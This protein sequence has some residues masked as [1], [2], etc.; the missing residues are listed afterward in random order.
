M[1]AIQ[2]M[3][4]QAQQSS[5]LVTTA[6]QRVVVDAGVIEIVPVNPAVI[7]VPYYNPWS[8]WGRSL[9]PIPALLSAAPARHR[10][11]SRTCLRPR[12]RGWGL[13]WLRLGFRRMGASLGWWDRD[14]RWQHL[15]FEQRDGLQSRLFWRSRPGRVRSWWSRRPRRLSRRCSRRG[16][17]VSRC[18][19]IRCS[20]RGAR[21][22]FGIRRC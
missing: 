2:A 6:Q 3:R 17:S 18:S 10:V 21:W 8:V 12:N 9:S 1:N 20:W 4:L 7:F 13:C 19:G 11:G 22:P 14:V 16:S 15:H 5:V